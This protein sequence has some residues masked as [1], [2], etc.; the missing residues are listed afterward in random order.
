VPEAAS[1]LILLPVRPLLATVQLV[2]LSVDRKTPLRVPTRR[3][4]PEAAISW[5]E[6]LVKPVFTAVQ[7][8]PLLL[9]RKTPPP[10]VATKTFVPETTRALKAKFVKP[11]I[12]RSPAS[13]VV[14]AKKHPRS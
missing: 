1:E 10:I 4:P 11:G 6:R 7:V 13:A 5:T 14:G 12:H 9:E 2:P 3:F 8:L